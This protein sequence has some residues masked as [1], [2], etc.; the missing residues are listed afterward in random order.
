MIDKNKLLNELL[1]I[2]LKKEA[3][4]KPTIPNSV[5]RELANQ[6]KEKILSTKTVD[7]ESAFASK[8]GGTVNLNVNDLRNL[9]DLIRWFASNQITF[10]GSD[11]SIPASTQKQ[12]PGPGWLIIDAATF[13][14]NRDENSQVIKEPF[15][16]NTQQVR[17]ALVTLRDTAFKQNNV[18]FKAM[19]GQAISSFNSQSNLKSQSISP[20]SDLDKQEKQL[21]E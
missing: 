16:I 17:E 3:Q 7:A 4:Q 12:A 13:D 5:V 1:E 14:R 8:S 11:L 2:G 18:V 9:G 21:S 19:I 10:K 15:W 6:L 20:Q